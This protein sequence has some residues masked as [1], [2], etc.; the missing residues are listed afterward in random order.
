MPPSSGSAGT[1]AISR[2]VLL[3]ALGICLGT[4]ALWSGRFRAARGRDDPR[5]TQAHVAVEGS[6]V[7]R[8]DRDLVEAPA[9]NDPSRTTVSPE[10]QERME[11]LPL[12]VIEPT[13][14]PLSG[15]VVH[16]WESGASLTTDLSGLAELPASLIDSGQRVTISAAGF[17]PRHLELPADRAAWVPSFTVQLHRGNAL[18]GVVVDPEGALVRVGVG[19]LAVEGNAYLRP[20]L[21]ERTLL[22]EPVMPFCRTDARGG[23]RLEGL[24]PS[25]SYRLFVAGRGYVAFDPFGPPVDPLADTPV[26]LHAS[27]LYGCRVRLVDEGSSSSALGKLLSGSW[28]PSADTAGSPLKKLDVLRHLPLLFDGSP[29]PEHGASAFERLF[30]F[31]SDVETPSIDFLVDAALPGYEE[32]HGSVPAE[33]I[34][35][36]VPGVTLPLRRETPGFGSID[37]ELDALGAPTGVLCPGERPVRLHMVSAKDDLWADVVLSSSGSGTVEGVPFGRYDV[38]LSARHAF[39]SWPQPGEPR[40]YVEVT[41]RRASLRIPLVGQG[42]LELS[43]LDPEG[44]SYSGPITGT[45]VLRHG[46]QEYVDSFAF[47]RPP[48]CFQLLPAGLYAVSVLDRVPLAD[49]PVAT[50]VPGARARLEVQLARD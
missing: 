5:A 26:V 28:F 38:E 4:V 50:V 30:L 35:G 2:R 31:A 16:A 3:V 23:F 34:L 49:A 10:E 20:E 9:S 47:P 32:V 6:N 41:E 42:A 43:L 44:A 37:L 29:S 17:V 40:Q 36:V 33:R 48:Y 1:G 45:I 8:I 22:G 21:I 14:G 18:S 24:S 12:R 15:S 39:F 27:Y 19:V 13:G 25:L 46:H 7:Q 11:V